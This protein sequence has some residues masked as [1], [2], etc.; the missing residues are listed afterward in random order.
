MVNIPN[1][2]CTGTVLSDRGWNMVSI[3]PKA[4]TKKVSKTKKVFKYRPQLVRKTKWYTIN[5][6]ILYFHSPDGEYYDIIP[7]LSKIISKGIEE[8]ES[9]PDTYNR[10]KTRTCNYA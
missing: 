6:N 7:P 10:V 5:N 4:N 8:S 1:I 9:R 3:K 2:P